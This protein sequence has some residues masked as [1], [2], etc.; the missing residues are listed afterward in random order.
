MK[1]LKE[2]NKTYKWNRLDL[3]MANY[4][5]ANDVLWNNETI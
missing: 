3:F 5:V 4:M 1:H 2:G